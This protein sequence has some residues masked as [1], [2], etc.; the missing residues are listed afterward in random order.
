MDAEP[1]ELVHV[2]FVDIPPIRRRGVRH[3]QIAAKAL[4]VETLG[5][6]VGDALGA[7]IPGAHVKTQ[8]EN[9]DSTVVPS[10]GSH[11]ARMIGGAEH[12]FGEDSSG[13]APAAERAVPDGQRA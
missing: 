2:R 6:L 3:A 1:F 4:G 8:R 11:A 9:A 12:V 13:P 7:A 5:E 10:L